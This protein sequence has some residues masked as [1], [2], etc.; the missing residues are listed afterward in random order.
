MTTERNG[1]MTTKTGDLLDAFT[2]DANGR[3][4]DGEI[5][6]TQSE[7][8]T[9]VLHHYENG[10][11]VFTHA[12]RRCAACGEVVTAASVGDQCLTCADAAGRRLNID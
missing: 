4:I 1:T 11:H 12:A 2:L 8:G 9:E 10:R 3:M 7:D 6:L 5:R